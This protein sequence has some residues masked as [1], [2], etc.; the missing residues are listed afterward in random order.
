V[1]EKVARN[2]CDIALSP[3]PIID[4][5]LI[6]QHKPHRDGGNPKEQYDLA[7]IEG[8]PRCRE[9]LGTAQV[10]LRW[11]ASLLT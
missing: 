1:F 2:R 4:V 7:R 3:T 10:S 6:D 11:F 5:G 8:K 9:G